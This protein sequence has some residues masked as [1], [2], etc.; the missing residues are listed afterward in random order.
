MKNKIIS[1]IEESIALKNLV[2]QKLANQIA[3][4]SLTLCSSIKSGNKIYIC[5]NG[6]SAADAQHFA[7]ELVVRYKNERKSIPCI[8]LTTDTSIITACAND[9]S[10]DQIFS[11]QIEGLGSSG[12]L[13]IGI[14]TSGNSQNIIEAFKLAKDKGMLTVCLTGKDGGKVKSM[15]LDH[16]IVVPSNSTARIQEVHELIL[17]AWC[18]MMDDEFTEKSN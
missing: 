15:D 6:G 5:G 17:H 11:R 7:A 3:L 1:I 8:A 12:D 9:Y 14:S 18:E 4:A 16:T 2:K 13:L 10:Y